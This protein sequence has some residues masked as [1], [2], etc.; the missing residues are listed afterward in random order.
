M[1]II[2]TDYVIHISVITLS[3]RLDAFTVQGLREIQERLLAEGKIYFVADLS[4]AT[5][6]D[7]AGMSALVSLLKR[8]RQAGGSVVLIGPNDP[9]AY[10]ILTLTRFDQVFVM[11]KSVKDAVPHL[12]K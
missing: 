1:D 5:F 2:V 9:A 12:A 10:R 7:S 11:V 3:G 4:G 6:M 8:A